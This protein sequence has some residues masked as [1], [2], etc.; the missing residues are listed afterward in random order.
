MRCFQKLQN[1][2]AVIQLES[3]IGGAIKNFDRVRVVTVPRARFLPVKRTQ[4]LLLVMSDLYEID[5]T[6]GVLQLVAERTSSPSIVLSTVYD[7]VDAFRARFASIPSLRALRSLRVDGDVS[8]G[9]RVR[10]VV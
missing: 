9:E 3:A 8:F 4:D 1:G 5:A 2:D 7:H 10:L 6:T